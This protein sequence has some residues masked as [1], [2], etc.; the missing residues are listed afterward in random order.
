[1]PNAIGTHNWC[2]LCQHGGADHEVHETPAVRVNA[3]PDGRGEPT[4]MCVQ[5]NYIDGYREPQL[6]IGG[7]EADMTASQVED[8]IATLQKHVELMRSVQITGAVVR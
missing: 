7:D 4:S 3:I 2:E 6:Y 5:M 1:M 8:L